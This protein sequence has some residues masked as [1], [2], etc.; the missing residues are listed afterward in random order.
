MFTV[1]SS[2]D[3]ASTNWI[4]EPVIA[5]DDNPNVLPF[6]PN[7]KTAQISHDS[8]ELMRRVLTI[9]GTEAINEKWFAGLNGNSNIVLIARPIYINLLLWNTQIIPNS[10]ARENFTQQKRKRNFWGKFRLKV[11]ILYHFRHY[12]KA[13]SKLL[14]SVSQLSEYVTELTCW[15]LGWID[16]I[17]DPLHGAHLPASCTQYPCHNLLHSSSKCPVVK[18]CE[19]EAW[20]YQ[21]PTI[22]DVPERFWLN[23]RI[24]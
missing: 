4:Q 18:S 14:E 5:H 9:Y 11:S 1:F 21:I 19:T 23:S 13:K 12:L 15:D 22:F 3:Q 6:G 10:R 17:P 16:L 8:L 2:I 24:S 20:S 7:K